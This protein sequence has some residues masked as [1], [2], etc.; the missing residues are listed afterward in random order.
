MEA[1]LTL[2]TTEHGLNRTEEFDLA[3]TCRRALEAHCVQAE[4]QGL[5]L[6]TELGHAI[7]SGDQDLA[8]RLAANLIDN[9]IRY[10]IPSGSVRVRTETEWDSAVLT[11]TNTGLPIPPELVGQLFEPFHRLIE[12]RASHPDGHGLGL[13]I[14]RSIATAHGADLDVQLPPDGGLAVRVRFRARGRVPA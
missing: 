7:I 3:E 1:L 13:S 10:N 8:E 9:A 5:R 2:A 12:D 11:V 6:D 4:H 14:V